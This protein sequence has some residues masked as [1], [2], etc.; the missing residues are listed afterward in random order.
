MGGRVRRA[1][2][3]APLNDRRTLLLVFLTTF[4]LY[5]SFSPLG[6][7]GMGYTMEEII[8]VDELIT[9][10]QGGEADKIHWPRNGLVPLIIHAPF[11]IPAHILSGDDFNWEDAVLSLEPVLFTSL[12][13]TLLFAWIL[14][15]TQSYAWAAMLA[16]G[17]AFATLLWPYAYIG[18]ET[19]QSLFLLAAAYLAIEEPRPDRWL[20]TLMF[21]VCVAF[22]VSA[23]STGAFLLPAGAYLVWEYFGIRK[24][25]LKNLPIAKVI[26][27]GAI[28][29][30]TFLVNTYV[31]NLFWINYGG[32]AHFIARWAIDEPVMFLFNLLSF[33][34][35][36]NKGL[37]VFAPLAVLGLASLHETWRKNL[38]IAIFASLALAGLAGGFSLLKDWADETWGTRYLHSAVAPLVLCLAA[39]R[40]GKHLKLRRELPI[41]A[42][43]VF[44]AWVSFLGSFFYYGRL[45]SSQNQTA[46]NTLEALQSDPVWNHVRFNLRLLRVW[47]RRGQKPDLQ[48]W[49]TPAHT[50]F[51]KPP[52]GQDRVKSVNLAPMAEPQPSLIRDARVPKTT[53]LGRMWYLLPVCLASG[54]VALVLLVIRVRRASLEPL[55]EAADAG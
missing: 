43:L 19:S 33:L 32:N 46:Q 7:A 6:V 55:D 40:S 1:R 23:K 31:R 36:P 34:L 38:P 41:L 27:T 5:L 3:E 44:G 47:Q 20:R 48:A 4:L 45:H 10:A 50:W 49:W 51:F 53:T 39:A 22:A 11:L 13:V 25:G 9:S 29:A 35:S 8:A 52:P 15:L 12:L 16:L 24:R 30:M 54:L 14:R 37:I 26:T 2:T 28:V 42:A 18:L 17:A 21:A